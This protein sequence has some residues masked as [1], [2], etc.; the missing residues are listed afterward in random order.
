MLVKLHDRQPNSA[1]NLKIDAHTHTPIACRL[2]F[3]A[4]LKSTKETHLHHILVK[5]ITGIMA[6]VVQF[7]ENS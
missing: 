4:Y 1:D 3:Y 5:E 6:N 2:T 7:V